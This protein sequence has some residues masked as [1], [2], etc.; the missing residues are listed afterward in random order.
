M[1]ISTTHE[2]K[3]V[4]NRIKI[5]SRGFVIPRI[6]FMVMSYSVSICYFA[7]HFIHENDYGLE[8]EHQSLS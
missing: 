3:L 4:L 8:H 6:S 7:F 1:I 5:S 2:N